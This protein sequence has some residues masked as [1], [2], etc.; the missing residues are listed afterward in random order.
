MSFYEECL[1]DVVKKRT[2]FCPTE[3]YKLFSAGIDHDQSDVNIGISE[4]DGSDIVFIKGKS[5]F[6]AEVVIYN[7]YFNRVGRLFELIVIMQ[8]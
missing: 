7:Y 6:M 4:V 8:P 5:K 1:L 3:A 2:E